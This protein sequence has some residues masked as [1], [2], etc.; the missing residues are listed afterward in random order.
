M[1]ALGLP[2]ESDR[3]CVLGPGAPH[4]GLGR[5]RAARVER[6]DGLEYDAEVRR[7]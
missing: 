6:Y 7:V 5:E 2:K 4:Q 1:L 3:V